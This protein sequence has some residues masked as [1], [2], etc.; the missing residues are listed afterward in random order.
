MLPLR[1]IYDVL[2]TLVILF[3]RSNISIMHIVQGNHTLHERIQRPL[4]TIETNQTIP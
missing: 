4:K 1:Q 2:T 3:Y